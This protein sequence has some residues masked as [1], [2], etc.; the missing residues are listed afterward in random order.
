MNFVKT[1]FDHPESRR[2]RRYP[3]PV[4]AVVIGERRYETL[5]WSLGGFLVKGFT[6]HFTPGSTFSGTLD[7]GEGV[8][9]LGF[10][11][12]VVRCGEPEAGHLAVQFVSLGANGIDILDR[13]IARRMFGRPRKV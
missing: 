9:Q 12:Q 5:N 13:Y 2:D 7:L 8:A 6:G 11:G 10:E 3:M 4:L 1:S